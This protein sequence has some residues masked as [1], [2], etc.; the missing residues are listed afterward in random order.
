MTEWQPI[1]T[2]PRDGT[3]IFV[4][5][6]MADA[7][8]AKSPAEYG[9]MSTRWFNGAWLASNTKSGHTVIITEDR[10][11]HWRPQFDF[12]P[13]LPRTRLAHTNDERRP[14]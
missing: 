10:L 11:T 1:E 14:L 4:V 5:Y 8:H 2:A 6:R 7:P 12:P 3:P 13:D 9:Q